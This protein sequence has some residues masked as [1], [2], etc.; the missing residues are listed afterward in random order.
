[1]SEKIEVKKSA[2]IH[3]DIGDGTLV[4]DVERLLD[5]S[6][7]FPGTPVSTMRAAA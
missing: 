2:T 4:V 6:Q 7:P 5:N 1:M 3:L